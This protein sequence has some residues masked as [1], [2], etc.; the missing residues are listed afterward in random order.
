MCR[1][2]YELCNRC[3]LCNRRREQGW[4]WRGH[5][6][7]GDLGL[8]YGQGRRCCGHRHGNGLRLGGDLWFGGD[9]R[10]SHGLGVAEDVLRIDEK[11][12]GWRRR[13]DHR[14]RALEPERHEHLADD[15]VELSDRQ[16]ECGG[17]LGRPRWRSGVINFRVTHG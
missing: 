9:L 16:Q 4:G 11:W 12:R 17:G 2:L 10:L 15:V 1:S 8:R 6:L 13:R 5:G 7:G 14:S 3:H